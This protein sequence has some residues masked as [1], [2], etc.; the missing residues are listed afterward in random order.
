MK[1]DDKITVYYASTSGAY[2]P[3]ILPDLVPALSTTL[4]LV[5]SMRVRYCPAFRSFYTNTFAVT[6]PLNF[7]LLK[8]QGMRLHHSTA[9]EENANMFLHMAD[10]GI[11]MLENQILMFSETPC[12]VEVLPPI[13]AANRPDVEVLPGVMDISAWFRPIHTAYVMP[14][15][16]VVSVKEGDVLHYLKFKTNAQV[17]FKEFFLTQKLHEY[18][19]MSITCGKLNNGRMFSSLKNYYDVFKRKRMSQ[20]ILREIRENLV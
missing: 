18:Y 13:L 6:S 3:L 4:P 5:N 10:D 8:G 7:D 1:N 2:S 20:K 12:E 14:D 19:Q 17:V 15:D 11:F 16:K 9:V